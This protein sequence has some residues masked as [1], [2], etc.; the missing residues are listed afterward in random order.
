MIIFLPLFSTLMCIF[1]LSP[2]SSSSS[3]PLLPHTASL[4]HTSSLSHTA[5]YPHMNSAPHTVSLPV[6]LPPCTEQDN[7][8]NK[9]LKTG[10]V[11]DIHLAERTRAKNIA[12]YGKE[13]REWMAVD[14][15]LHP[16][17]RGKK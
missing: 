7:F 8:G 10:A 11:F 13:E 5:S 1:I 17:V 6:T 3:L 15:I 2:P 16:Q 14:R 12:T 4:P 9:K